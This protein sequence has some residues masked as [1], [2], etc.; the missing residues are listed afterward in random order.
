MQDGAQDTGRNG[1]F[2]CVL[3][4][5]YMAHEKLQTLQVISTFLYFLNKH[6]RN[7]PKTEVL[8]CQKVERNQD[9]SVKR[10]PFIVVLKNKETE[11][12][13]IPTSDSITVSQLL[14]GKHKAFNIKSN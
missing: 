10:T 9:P 12:T 13:L 5:S 14:R 6:L 7:A 4:L 1:A 3:A 11:M 2:L 8:I